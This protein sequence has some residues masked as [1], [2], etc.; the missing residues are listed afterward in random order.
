MRA[1]SSLSLVEQDA[2]RRRICAISDDGWH[3]PAGIRTIGAP[4]HRK[5]A[6]CR[7]CCAPLR[8][9]RIEHGYLP[10]EEDLV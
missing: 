9:L 7:S 10:W 8:A 5:I 2:L 4:V 6:T 1:K 3:H